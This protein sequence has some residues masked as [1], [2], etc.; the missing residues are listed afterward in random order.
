MMVLDLQCWDSI[1]NVILHEQICI[2]AYEGIYK[3]SK[4]HFF[5]SEFVPVYVSMLE[6]KF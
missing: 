2:V 1:I 3:L 4:Y 6:N 5:F